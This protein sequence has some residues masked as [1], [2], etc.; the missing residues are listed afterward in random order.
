MIAGTTSG[1]AL[2][3]QPQIT[4][5]N[6]KAISVS[7]E[8][9]SITINII[10]P[11]GKAGPPGKNGTN[12]APGERGPMGFNGTTTFCFKFAN[13]TNTCGSPLPPIIPGNTTSVNVTGTGNTTTTATHAKHHHHNSS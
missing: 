12:G 13:G 5:N 10:S 9:A 1:A 8:K 2:A 7:S 3:S 4:I 11:P 6:V